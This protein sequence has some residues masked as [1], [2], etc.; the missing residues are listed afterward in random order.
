MRDGEAQT[1]FPDDE[2]YRP[3]TAEDCGAE[4]VEPPPPPPARELLFG[5]PGELGA[6]EGGYGHEE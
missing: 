3:M 5:E 4:A 1:D 6:H 2:E